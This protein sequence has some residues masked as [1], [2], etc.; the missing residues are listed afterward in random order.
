KQPLQL[1]AV[2]ITLRFKM[3]LQR[4]KMPFV[5]EGRPVAHIGKIDQGT[6]ERRRIDLVGA[7][8]GRQ[9]GECDRHQCPA[10]TEGEEVGRLSGALA[11]LRYGGYYAFKDIN[12]Y[13]L[14]LALLSWFDPSYDEQATAFLN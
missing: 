2:D 7:I 9:P 3:I 8:L 13:I 12:G 10:K 4:G 5:D 6:D 11:D 14:V 1:D